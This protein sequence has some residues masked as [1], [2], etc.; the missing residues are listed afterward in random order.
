L[1]L[2]DFRALVRRLQQQI[3]DQ[4]ETGVVDVEISPKTVPDPVHR[5]VFT[6]GEC[7]PLSWTGDG[8]DLQSRI[9]LFYGSF[10]A[11]ARGRPDFDW[12]AETWETLTHEIRHHLEFRAHV[13]LLEAYDWAVEQNVARLEGHAFDP[14]FYRSGERIAEH[15]YKVEDDVFIEA[16]GEFTWHR[17]R[18]RAPVAGIQP[19]AFLTLEGLAEAPHSAAVLVI[20]KRIAL[21]DL[22]SRA[23]VTQRAAQVQPID[24]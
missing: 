13:D 17:R 9:V 16:D 12:R 1:T 8:S 10:L 4:F 22:W 6:M 15:V 20:P 24:G 18:Y 14:L 19:P 3:P 5:G 7:I 21:R 2:E 11:L 23:P